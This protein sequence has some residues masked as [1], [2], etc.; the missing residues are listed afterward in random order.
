MKEEELGSWE[1]NPL[2]LPLAAAIIIIVVAH[3]G[4]GTEM[5]INRNDFFKNF[6]L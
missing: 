1:R 2:F 4:L 5:L 6:H 3:F